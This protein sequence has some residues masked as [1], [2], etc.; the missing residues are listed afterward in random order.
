MENDSKEQIFGQRTVVVMDGGLYENYPQY[1]RY[2]KEA[3]VE[4]LGPKQ[5]N[6]IA[7]EHTKDG[8]GIDAA[9]LAAANSKYA[10]Q[11]STR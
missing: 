7:I 10:A 5:S 9:L 11:F 1:R 4:L 6:H 3:V 2:M 8:S